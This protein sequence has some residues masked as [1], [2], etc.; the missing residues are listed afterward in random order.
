MIDIDEIE[1]LI[2]TSEIPAAPVSG[3]T[4]LALI[5]EVRALREDAELF[6]V[7]VSTCDALDANAFD[8]TNQPG[9]LRITVK[10]KTQT[11][12]ELR[13]KIIDFLKGYKERADAA[14]GAK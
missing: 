12:P 6:R 4:A 10:H 7:L 8:K 3:A 5:A 2:K 9:T 11:Y 13:M 1:R 14:R